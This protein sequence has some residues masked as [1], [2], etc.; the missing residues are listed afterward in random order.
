MNGRHSGD[1]L[2]EISRWLQRQI[3]EG[4]ARVVLR[5]QATPAG[6]QTVREW[7]LVDV[8]AI[9]L[10]QTI[11]TRAV[12]DAIHQ[13]GDVHYGLFAYAN[14]QKNYVDRWFLELAGGAGDVVSTGS[15]AS[16]LATLDEDPERSQRTTLVGLLMKHT[17]A[18]AQLA[19]GSNVDIVQHYK[20]ESERKD[21]RIRELE[22][23]QTKVLAMYEELI[24][25]KHEREID[26]LR[27]TNSENRKNQLMDKV[28]MLIPV[29]LSKVLPPAKS[30][31]LGEDLMRELFKSLKREQLTAI[32]SQLEPEQAAVIQ[33]IYLAYLEHDAA[34]EEAK[35]KKN[36]TNGAASAATNGA[37]NAG[38]A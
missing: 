9:E 38:H 32:V 5:Q 25:L 8:T 20:M 33:T 30:P 31:A 37:A 6:N 36:G 1:Q 27:A 28:N 17:H 3:D 16:S 10:A 19:I 23:R 24:S 26:Q 11:H 14:G 15:T 34:A 2:L 21:Q 4:R 7:P 22:E 35:K 13:R 29:A 18:S 12:E